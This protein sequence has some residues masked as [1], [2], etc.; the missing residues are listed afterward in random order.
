[1]DAAPPSFDLAQ[2]APTA[3]HAA[4]GSPHVGQR[5]AVLCVAGNSLYHKLPNVEAYDMKRDVRTFAGGMPVVGHPPCRS[6]SA[7]CAHQAKPLPGEKD[8]GPLVV[9]WL[10]KCGGVLEHPAHSRLF[11]HCELPRPGEHKE[12]MWTAEVLQAWWGDSRTKK[13]WLCFF[14]IAPEKVHF[15]FKLH[16]AAGDR[17]R[18]QVMSKHQRSATNPAMAEWL[19]QTASKASPLCSEV[20]AECTNPEG[21]Q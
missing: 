12:G 8:L 20:N 18:W 7:Y 14:G 5:V 3:F 1:M 10:K 2:D 13:T 19:I 15:P 6:W 9:E 11:A 21:C 16:D 4:F 17:R